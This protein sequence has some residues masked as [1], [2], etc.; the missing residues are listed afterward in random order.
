MVVCRQRGKNDNIAQYWC[1]N[2]YFKFLPTAADY[3]DR[4]LM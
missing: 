1:C 4:V 2:F 3:A